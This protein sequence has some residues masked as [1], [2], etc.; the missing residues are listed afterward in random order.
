MQA[1]SLLALDPVAE[2]LG[3][4]NSYGFR[5]ERSTAD[6][7]E[8][9]FAALSRKNSAQWILE[10]DIKACFDRISHE[11]LLQHI[12]M[13]KTI[14]RK[15]LKAGFI[16]KNVL[17]TTEEGTPQGGICSPV[18]ANMTL[19][20]LE[21]KLREKFPKPPRKSSKEKVNFIRFADDF[22]ITGRSKEVLEDEVKPLV[23]QFMKERG[24]ELSPE[25]TL[26]THIDEGFDL[27]GQR[28]RKYKGNCSS[29][30]P[31][32]TSIPFLKASEKSLETTSKPPPE[33]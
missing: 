14:L 23:E 26:I 24:L 6:A 15:W 8:Q 3:D 12:P 11:W 1:L 32:R 33:T 16:D 28:L 2:T 21:K 10:G 27:L 19:D 29:L 31:E 13:D 4:L 17:H 20:G 18:L 5:K 22:L 9:C 25:K 7:I 30:P